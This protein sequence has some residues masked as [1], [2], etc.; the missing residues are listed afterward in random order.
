MIKTAIFLLVTLFIPKG[1]AFEVIT[2]ET[3]SGELKELKIDELKKVLT[4]EQVK[5]FDQK[6]RQF[7]QY[8]AFNLKDFLLY[9]S[10][11]K[12]ISH[13]LQIKTKNGYLPIIS[14]QHINNEPGY[15]AFEK[16]NGKMNTIDYRT[17]ELV[18]TGPL[19]LVWKDQKR[20]DKKKN[21]RWVY[22][23]N[24]LSFKLAIEKFVSQ[25][26]DAPQTVMMGEILFNSHCLRCHNNETETSN[27]I[28][29]NIF[30][31]KSREWI[32]DYVANPS[33]YNKKTIMPTFQKIF[34]DKVEMEDIIN[35][36][37]YRH[38]PISF[39]KRSLIRLNRTLNEMKRK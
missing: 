13:D 9:I 38:D 32:S 35:Y 37:D 15:L 7:E 25:V 24:Y 10:G 19:Y 22:Q 1:W 18:E 30:E 26:K 29:P 33:N 3:A 8:N 20:R 23:I 39:K 5:I 12:L 11:E 16:I 14:P 34:Q 27:L 21:L 17:E 28:K 2:F 31:S 6:N 36:L 4:V